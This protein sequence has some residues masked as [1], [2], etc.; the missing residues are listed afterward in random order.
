M[1]TMDKV[2]SI[3]HLSLALSLGW[4]LVF[5]CVKNYRLDAFR[6]RLFALRDQLF[7]YA[8]NGEVP[9]DH[10]AYQM[11]RTRINGMI[12][13]AH[14]VSFLRLFLTVTVQ[15]LS[16]DTVAVQ[17]YKRWQEAV[18]TLPSPEVRERLR[19]CH[20]NML[21][22]MVRHMVTGSPILLTCLVGFGVWALVTGAAKRLLAAFTEHLPGL[23]LLEDQALLEGQ[24]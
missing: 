24:A 18:E 2:V 6:Q 11:L 13:F 17:S 20:D 21:V 22:L 4:V 16:P 23:D 19:A 8:A 5:W 14:R 15:Q 7:D 3:V 9:F 10:P 12:R 1:M